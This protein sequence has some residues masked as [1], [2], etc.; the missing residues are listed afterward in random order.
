MPRPLLVGHIAPAVV[1]HVVGLQ[2]LEPLTARGLAVTLQPRDM[3]GDEEI[4]WQGQLGAAANSCCSPLL[5][6][7]DGEDIYGEPR[8]GEHVTGCIL[9]I[10][11]RPPV[12]FPAVSAS[13]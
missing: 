1:V 10:S 11:P 5:A 4:H 6:R 12:P 7:D 13:W 3:V 2:L 9:S 8:G